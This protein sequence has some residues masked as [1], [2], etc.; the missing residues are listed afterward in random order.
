MWRIEAKGGRKVRKGSY[1]NVEDGERVVMESPGIL[2]G[3]SST[4]Y[5]RFHPIFMIVVGP[6]LGLAYAIFLPLI[7]ILM[8]LGVA[9][10]AVFGAAYRG[11][12]EI[13]GFGW[14]PSEAYLAGKKAPKS[15]KPDPEPVDKTLS[16]DEPGD[17]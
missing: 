3:D 17:R 12:R 9:G 13:A 5:L 16:E 6:V 11:M 14:R 15:A 10:E 4:E 2:P 7:G 8:V 1:W